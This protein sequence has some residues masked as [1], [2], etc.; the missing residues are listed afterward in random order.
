MRAGDWASHLLRA[1]A[2][3]AQNPHENGHPNDEL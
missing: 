3:T 1:I 2:T